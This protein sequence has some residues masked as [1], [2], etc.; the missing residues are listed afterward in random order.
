MPEA[1]KGSLCGWKGQNLD[2]S[3]DAFPEA[4]VGLRGGTGR[5]GR[6]GSEGE[7]MWGPR[8]KGELSR[9]WS[10]E[11]RLTFEQ[12]HL[13]ADVR[14][15]NR[16]FR[17]KDGYRKPGEGGSRNN[18]GELGG[19]DGGAKNSYIGSTVNRQSPEF[20]DELDVGPERVE[21]N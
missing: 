2:T 21:R 3:E 8:G 11:I 10:N 15:E 4:E 1:H 16:L 17:S 19:R 6:G 5:E 14:A 9:R 18:P 12:G 13:A 20:A 7:E